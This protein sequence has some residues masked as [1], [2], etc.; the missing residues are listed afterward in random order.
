MKLQKGTQ[1]Y[2][3]ELELTADDYNYS[4]NSMGDTTKAKKTKMIQT[5]KNTNNE[6]FFT[7]NQE[8]ERK[9]QFKDKAF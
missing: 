1:K 5:I 2:I 4:K 6:R 7:R 8:E 9:P 3:S